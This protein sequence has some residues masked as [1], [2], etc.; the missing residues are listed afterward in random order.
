M[1]APNPSADDYF[2]AI[3]HTLTT[4]GMV[5]SALCGLFETVVSNLASCPPLRA[6]YWAIVSFEGKQKMADA[7]MLEVFRN[8]PPFLTRWKSINNRLIAKN[9]KRNS[10]AHGSVVELMRVDG[11]SKISF[12]PYFD[13]TAKEHFRD[14]DI[15]GGLAVQDV[16]LMQESFR[17][18]MIEL[19]D[20]M[21]DYHE[22]QMF[23]AWPKRLDG[24]TERQM[25][26]PPVLPAAE[27]H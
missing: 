23:P 9:K 1:S 2:A 12:V 16:R 25:Y 19:G 21:S 7:A 6:A 26:R 27:A 24:L 14:G 3:G 20:L 8:H 22:E 18:L 4:W 17:V 5:E 10:V 13:K 11:T 15:V